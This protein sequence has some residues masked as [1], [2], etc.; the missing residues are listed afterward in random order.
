MIKPS[1]IFCDGGWVILVDS[2][3]DSFVGNIAYRK[4]LVSTSI[5]ESCCGWT[6]SVAQDKL[7]CTSQ[8]EINSTMYKDLWRKNSSLFCYHNPLYDQEVY[9]DNSNSNTFGAFRLQVN[10][11]LIIQKNYDKQ[12]LVQ[13]IV[14]LNI[15][16]EYL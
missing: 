7:C 8:T 3:K 15:C 1:S 16:Q 10:R 13:Q 12:I 4:T 11:R 2:N 6:S 9:V 5:S 14:T